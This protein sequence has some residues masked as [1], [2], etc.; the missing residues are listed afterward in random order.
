MKVLYWCPFCITPCHTNGAA[1][2]H[3][4]R[5]CRDQHDAETDVTGFT[6]SCTDCGVVF[7]GAF[8]AYKHVAYE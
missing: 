4:L 1:Q 8:D 6:W 2:F 7:L 5:K 3:S